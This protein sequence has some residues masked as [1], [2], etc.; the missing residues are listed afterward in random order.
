MLGRKE[1][2]IYEAQRA[3]DLC[4]EIKDAV[5]GPEYATNLAFVYA[6]SGEMDQAVAL[7]SRLLTTLAAERLTL[8]HLRLSWELDPL[9]QN[10]RFQKILEG[11]APAT[12]YK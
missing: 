7:L 2:A 12:V 5:S 4:L 3:V 9:R 6:Q 8:A 11:P 10:L 1:E